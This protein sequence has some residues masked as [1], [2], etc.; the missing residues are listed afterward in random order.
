MLKVL[1]HE[2]PLQ[3]NL[4]QNKLSISVTVNGDGDG[5]DDD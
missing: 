3:Q 2:K 4:A 1:T 5:E